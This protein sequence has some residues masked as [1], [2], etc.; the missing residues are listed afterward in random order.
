MDVDTGTCKASTF[1]LPKTCDNK[2]RGGNGGGGSWLKSLASIERDA[3]NSGKF[4]CEV[5]LVIGSINAGSLGLGPLTLL[6]TP[7]VGAVN[8]RIDS[9]LISGDVLLG[10]VQ[11]MS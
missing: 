7:L 3:G 11:M 4:C 6:E 5:V 1:V 2:G 10:E 8:P 9:E